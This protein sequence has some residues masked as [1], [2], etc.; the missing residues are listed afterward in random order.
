LVLEQLYQGYRKNKGLNN[1]G[2]YL[3]NPL[4]K[5]EDVE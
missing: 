4:R 1:K 3:C 2:P 5:E